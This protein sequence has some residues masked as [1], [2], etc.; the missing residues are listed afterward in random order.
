ME[1]VQWVDQKISG[2]KAPPEK[3]DTAQESKLTKIIQKI[4]NPNYDH[5]LDPTEYQRNDKQYLGPQALDGPLKFLPW[6]MGPYNLCW[7]AACALRLRA[8]RGT[9]SMVGFT[10]TQW[11]TI[12]HQSVCEEKWIWSLRSQRPKVWF[13]FW[14]LV[15]WCMA[16]KHRAWWL[17]LVCSCLWNPQS[18][19]RP[20]WQSLQRLELW[21]KVEAKVIESSL[22][23]N[24]ICNWEAFLSTSQAENC[25]TLCH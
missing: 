16:G 20:S 12:L 3:F 13:T 10:V 18:L 2:T 6:T 21:E 25:G 23:F 22:S 17:R 4:G 24:R 7:L 15:V 8:T 14:C 5:R 1:C 19:A 9:R 11:V